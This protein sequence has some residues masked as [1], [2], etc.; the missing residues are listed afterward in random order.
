M[1]QGQGPPVCGRDDFSYRGA[2]DTDFLDHVSWILPA[3]VMSAHNNR[4][5]LA[6]AVAV[7]LHLGGRWRCGSEPGR[8]HK[9]HALTRVA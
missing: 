2:A 6:A 5:S 1:G 3:L 7:R 8:W 9:H 4:A